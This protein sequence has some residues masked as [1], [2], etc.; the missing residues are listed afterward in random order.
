MPHFF[1]S[2]LVLKACNFIAALSLLEQFLIIITLFSPSLAHCGPP[3]REQTTTTNNTHGEH[4][5]L[6]SP[7]KKHFH[8][9]FIRIEIG[10]V[11]SMMANGGAATLEEPPAL[12]VEHYEL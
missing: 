7:S 4:D 12:W 2:A 5:G 6:V 1:H 11:P 9:F 8:A 10:D 3:S